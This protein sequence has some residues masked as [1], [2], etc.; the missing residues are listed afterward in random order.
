MVLLHSSPEHLP[1]INSRNECSVSWRH[2]TMMGEQVQEER[3]FLEVLHMY[4]ILRRYWY[5]TYMVHPTLHEQSVPGDNIHVNVEVHI[6]MHMYVL[7][8][9]GGTCCQNLAQ[10][11][12]HHRWAKILSVIPTWILRRQSAV[13]GRQRFSPPCSMVLMHYSPM[14]VVDSSFFHQ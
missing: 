2:E 10:F 4:S 14:A 5:G 3:R 12:T 6:C 11:T 9:T 8:T 1:L 13:P 7:G